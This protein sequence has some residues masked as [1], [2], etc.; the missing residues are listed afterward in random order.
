MRTIILTLLIAV[1][2]L[3]SGN[4]QSIKIEKV[5][6]G[7]NFSQDGDNLKFGE[8]V[9]LLE[10][11]EEAY[12]LIKTA[13]SQHT[14]SQILG[15]VGGFL[16]GWPIGRAVAGGEANWAMAGIGA[17][18]VVVA[19]PIS[20]KS[21]NNAKSAVEIYNAEYSSTTKPSNKPR[22]TLLARGNEIGIKLSF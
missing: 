4:S 18:I 5:F 17:G 20:I 22:F 8:L 16:I 7:Y 15:G 13:H 6:G 12:P 11:N 10:K 3:V 2:A 21:A 9:Y 14:F 1:F 19:I